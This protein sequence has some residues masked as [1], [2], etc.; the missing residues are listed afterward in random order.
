M[1]KLTL[2]IDGDLILYAACAAVEKEVR[3]DEDNHILFSNEFE[4]RAI[5][6]RD[7]ARLFERFDTSEH[8]IALTEG[9]VFRLD[10]YPQYKS[11]RAGTR[12]PICFTAC[13]EWLE[14]NYRTV[15]LKGLEA[16]DVLGIF[17]TRDPNTII[18]SRDKDM[19][20]IPCTLW[21]GKQVRKISE[22]EA[23]YFHLLQTLTGDTTD[24][25]PG[26]PGIGPKRAEK[27]LADESRSLWAGVVCAYTQA[28][29]SEADALI[30]ARVARIL[31]NS[32][33]D[34][35][36]KLPI[37]WSPDGQAL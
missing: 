36:K 8:V 3:W 7:L 37:L 10:I 21:D 1:S 29:L 26:C 31:R 20:G 24:G 28:G 22:R 15:K 19:R 13:R 14:A 16:D 25:Y 11:N 2:L 12:K 33:W 23:D 30:Q 17:A 27:L 34:S 9:P 32:D 6:E 18:V 4:A 35:E 5:V